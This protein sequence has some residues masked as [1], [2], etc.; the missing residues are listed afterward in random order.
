ML[1][2]AAINRGRTKAEHPAV[3]V[4]PE[5]QSAAMVECLKAGAN[6]IHLHVRSTGDK[7]SGKESLYL[8]DVAR[9]LSDILSNA[10]KE[11]TGAW[12]AQIGLSTGA[13][14]LPDLTARLRAIAD[15]EVLPGFASV[16]FSE[17]DLVAI[18]ELLLS[19]GVDVEAGLCDADAAQVFLNSGWRRAVFACCLNRRSRSL[20]APLI[21]CAQWRKCW[22]REMQSWSQRLCDRV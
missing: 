7:D 20:S 9:T 12:K 22:N 1:I 21:P 10:L 19:R 18:A 17:D 2:K 14:I 5:E 16:N 11:N 8:E 13:W 3:P 15:W 4:S 6:A